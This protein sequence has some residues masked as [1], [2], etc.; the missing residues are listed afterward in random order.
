[1]ASRVRNGRRAG[2]RTIRIVMLVAVLPLLYLT[3]TL[4]QVLL[5]ASR[6]GARPVEAIV[7]LGAAQYHGRPSP[8]LQ[9]RLDH[10]AALYE[11]RIAPLVVVTGGRQEG[12]RF[13]E[14]SASAD[15][16]ARR[17]IPQ[18]ALLREVQGRSSYESLAA[19]AR[20][21]RRRGAASVVLVSDPLHAARIRAISR[22]V[23]MDA[24][25]S[26]ARS[27]PVARKPR[28]QMAARE[29]LA[30]AI[31]RVVGFRRLRNL[32]LHLNLEAAGAHHPGAATFTG[33][34]PGRGIRLWGSGRE[35]SPPS[36]G[37]PARRGPRRPPAR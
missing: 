5:A 28:W 26:P 24:T 34:D 8:V 32:G 14:A 22:E 4:L 13:T 33:V 20:L 11:D 16:L 25:V 30:V 18:E 10:A 27:D 36:R 12:D 37:V 17:G 19:T 35:G 1:M 23:G 7:V 21:L 9:A 31:G 3:V 15:Y 2:Q 29:T 6:D